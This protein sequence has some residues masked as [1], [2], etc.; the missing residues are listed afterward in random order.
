MQLMTNWVIFVKDS[1]VTSQSEILRKI[2][3]LKK[4]VE[5]L[6]KTYIR[7]IT[8]TERSSSPWFNSSLSRMKNKKQRKFRQAR[9]L[10]TPLAWQKYRDNEKEFECLAVKTKC[11][12]FFFYPSKH[13]E[14]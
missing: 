5:Q 11:T 4:K 2:G 8:V 12:L 6:T 7:T 1:S 13:A 10:N 14:K 3:A 9:S